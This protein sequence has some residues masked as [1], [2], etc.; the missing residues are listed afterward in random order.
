MVLR[1]LHGIT[2][3]KEGRVPVPCSEGISAR[4]QRDEVN[5][6][7]RRLFS[8]NYSRRAIDVAKLCLT[9]KEYNHPAKECV[10]GRLYEIGSRQR[11]FLPTSGH[12]PPP[13]SGRN[14]GFG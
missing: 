11:W 9:W 8:S 1:L 14:V 3:V 12:D 2:A 5:Y 13:R 4:R 7:L 10:G 6:L